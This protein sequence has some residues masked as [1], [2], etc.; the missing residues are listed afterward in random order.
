LGLLPRT[1]HR[2]LFWLI[3]KRTDE[4]RGIKV[5]GR[6]LA[7]LALGLVFFN[8]LFTLCVGVM[9]I[10]AHTFPKLVR[11]LV[12]LHIIGADSGW[13]NLS[14]APAPIQL[15]YATALAYLTGVFLRAPYEAF[16]RPFRVLRGVLWLRQIIARLAGFL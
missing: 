14:P 6:S 13:L 10:W 4:A 8:I 5:F 16:G 11:A 2:L 1:C 12:D 7:A 15:G 3:G 9:A